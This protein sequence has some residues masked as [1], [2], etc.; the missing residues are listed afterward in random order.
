MNPAGAHTGHKHAPCGLV[1]VSCVR[2]TQY[3]AR[4][5]DSG[6]RGERR[7]KSANISKT[8]RRKHNSIVGFKNGAAKTSTNDSIVYK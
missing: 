7:E 8:A 2:M 6:E 5:P 3:A 1:F 4:L